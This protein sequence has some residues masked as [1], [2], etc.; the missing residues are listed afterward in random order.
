M[1]T[2][3]LLRLW[4]DYHNTE[5]KYVEVMIAKPLTLIGLRLICKNLHETAKQHL[6]GHIVRRYALLQNVA[7]AQSELLGV[8][9]F[10]GAVLKYTE[11]LHAL[12]DF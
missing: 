4:L 3:Y 5:I 10:E 2:I 12:Y 11:Q 9:K 7:E 8:M 6:P 1:K